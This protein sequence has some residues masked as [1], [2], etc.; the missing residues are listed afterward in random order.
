[1]ASGYVKARVKQINLDLP[2]RT[3]G[4][5]QLSQSLGF[6]VLF[7]LTRIAPDSCLFLITRK[8]NPF[9]LFL[10]SLPNMPFNLFDPACRL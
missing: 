5:E 9:F 3:N 10:F 7:S 8:Q 2:I 4:M 6:E 1:M